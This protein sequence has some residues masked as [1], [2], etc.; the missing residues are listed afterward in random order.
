[1]SNLNGIWSVLKRFFFGTYY[2]WIALVVAVIVGLIWG[3]Q[4][5]VFT[6]FGIVAAVILYVFGRQAWWWITKTGDYKKRDEEN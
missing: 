5:G 1:M 6:G 3:T 2:I 4:A